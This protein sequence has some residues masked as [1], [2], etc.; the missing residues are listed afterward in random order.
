MS[1]ETTFDP[2]AFRE[3]E[4]RGWNRLYRGYHDH[5]E[6]LTTQ[7]I[8][9]MLDAT[10]VAQGMDVLDVASGPGYV[11]AAAAARG[12]RTVGLDLSENM[13]RLAA[14]NNPGLRFQAGDAEELPFPDRHFDV[15][16]INFGILHFPDADKALSEAH[17]VLKPGGRIGFTAWSGPKNSGIGIAMAAVEKEGTLEVDLPPGT[18]VFRFA[19]HAECARVLGGIGFTDVT[20]TDT[21]LTWRLPGPDA[22]MECFREATVRT[23]GLLDAQD[24]TVLP[25]IAAAMT[26][27]CKPFDKDGH[28]DLPMPANLTTGA[29]A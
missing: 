21:L 8:P 20:S 28:T 19:D 7:V 5:W 22:L 23:S 13:V 11:S 3:F 18:P 1:G 6:H 16:L 24:P 29:K 12:A 17:R 15:V 14:G 9:P 27:A 2:E 25:A 26:E 4:H 10:G